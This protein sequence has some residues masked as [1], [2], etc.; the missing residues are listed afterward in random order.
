MIETELVNLREGLTTDRKALLINLEQKI[1]GTFAEIGA[2]QEVARHFF[3]VGGA[4][5]TIAK[6]MSA[7]D[8]TFSDEIYGKSGRYVSH[9][10][11]LSMLSHEYRLLL[12][13][14]SE[15]RGASTNFFVFA[16]TVSA[17]NYRGNNECHGWMGV[18]FQTE[19]LGP[20]NDIIIH[21]RM[22]DREN[23]LQ[24]QALGI[25]GVNL[26]YGAFHYRNDPDKFIQSLIDGLSTERIEVD[27]I[28]FSGPNLKIDN[29]LL[30][31]KL[32]QN[33][34]T[35]ATMF[36][37]DGHVLQP[38]EILYKKP[39]LVERG[40]FRPVTHVNIDMLKCAKQQFLKDPSVQENNPVILFELT[41][42]NLLSEG[43]LDSS[44]FL[45]RA[46][47]LSALGHTVLISNYQ[48]FYRL[49]GFFAR[50]TTEPIGVVIGLNNLLQ[51]FNDKFYEQLE[52]GILES[53]GRLFRNQ[54]RLYCYPMSRES[55]IKFA[56]STSLAEVPE[57][58]SKLPE[59]ITVNDIEVRQHLYHLYHH[60]LNSG[61]IVSISGYNKDYLDIFSREVLTKI[62]QPGSD[63]EKL[64]PTP[65]AH[66]I[67]SRKMFAYTG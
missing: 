34:L 9:E 29:R 20:S 45:A 36:S 19:P 31:L 25:I 66:I 3:R 63:W 23:L 17:K 14:L 28:E 37:P 4:A 53:F 43:T 55:F 39:I 13:R 10:R 22:T 8:M 38:S 2:G 50:Y 61:H 56:Q 6:T 11:L 26:I 44:D 32:V 12:E 57:D 30:S 60:L 54:V 47:T 16:D 24:Q 1:F 18:R 46:D 35:H 51:I 5:G 52:G 15:K 41:L 21:V 7:Y 58:M 59:V 62:S 42:K 33:K 65:A 48:E 49:T 67:K 40:S 64:V 27:M